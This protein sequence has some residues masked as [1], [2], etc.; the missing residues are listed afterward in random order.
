VFDPRTPYLINENPNNTYRGVSPNLGTSTIPSTSDQ[1]K[2][3]WRQVFSSTSLSVADSGRYIF[4]NLA[5]F[6]VITASMVLFTKAEAAFRKGDKS[7]ALDAYTKGINQSF[8]FLIANYEGRIPTAS[9]ITTATRAAYLSNPAVVPVSPSDLTLSQ[10]MLQKYIALYGYGVHETWTDLRRFHYTDADA[11][12]K[13]VYAGFKLPSTLTI[14]N[15]GKPVYRC[16][17]RYNSEYLYNIPALQN[18]G[19]LASDYHTKE[20]WFMQP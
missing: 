7:V 1:P 19:A 17:P 15:S 13:P 3:F 4:N 20:Q 14:Y 5:P 10:I 12:G 9:K 6:P 2:T 18:I 16:R 11:S 8:D